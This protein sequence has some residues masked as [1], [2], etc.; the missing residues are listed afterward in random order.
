MPYPPDREDDRIGC[1]GGDLAAHEVAHDDAASPAVDDDEIEHLGARVHLHGPGVDL[2]RQRLVRAE[3]QLLTGLAAG[4]EG[5]LHLD[6]AEGTGVEKTAVLARERD[7]LRDALVDDRHARLREPVDVRLP[8]AEVPALDGVVE[9]PVDGVAVVAVVLRRVDAALGRDRVGP[10][11]RV[12]VA[13]LL[14]VVALLTEGGAGRAAGQSGADD[15]HGE[16]AA[17]GGIHQLGFELPGVPT[18]VDRPGRRLGVRDRF[19]EEVPA[20]VADGLRR[21]LGGR[22]RRLR[23]GRRALRLV[24]GHQLT[25]PIRTATGTMMK[26][27]VRTAARMCAV[28]FN[29]R[30]VLGLFTP[31]VW[32]ALQNPWSTCRPSA[33]MATM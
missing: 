5:A 14:D 23:G 16:L 29:T 33:S 26:P 15:D 28:V 20:G 10:A 3:Q 1:V 7:A 21:G 4:V 17:V 27:T 13:E 2:A 25:T 31:S 18:L 24:L 9:E 8:G 30:S 19:A 12:L 32:A 6:A 11:R 22:G